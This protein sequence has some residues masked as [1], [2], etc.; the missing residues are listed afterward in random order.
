MQG[1]ALQPTTCRVCISVGLSPSGDRERLSCR[2][3]TRAMAMVMPTLYVCHGGGPMPL[4]G[5]ARHT[6]LIAHLREVG[7]SL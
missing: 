1:G 3:R 2:R 4:M 6:E 7:E 5:E